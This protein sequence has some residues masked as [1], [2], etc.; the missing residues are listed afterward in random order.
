[1][2]AFPPV[3]TVSVWVD[4]LP[5]PTYRRAYLS[6][7]RVFAAVSPL[8]TQLA[9]RIW[10]EDDELVF[11]RAGRLIR[12]HVE[13]QGD[14]SS[15]FVPLAAVLRG[16]GESLQYDRGA[17]RVEIRTHPPLIASPTPFNPS[18]PSVAP[19]AVFTPMPIQTPRPV[20]SGSA[21]PRRT[22]LPLPPP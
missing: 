1:V 22:P 19:S 10:F 20:W 4:G 7:G 21:L 13:S 11:E 18:G 5:V 17:R 2:L 15:T 12:I 16:L 3:I 9:D 8:L 14:L 6:G